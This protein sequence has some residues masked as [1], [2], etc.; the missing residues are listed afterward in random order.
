LPN[1]GLDLQ[2]ALALQLRGNFV[3]SPGPGNAFEGLPDIPI[4]EFQLKFDQGKLVTISRDLCTG[5]LP[6]FSAN[7]VGHNGAQLSDQVPATV[8]GCGG[9]GK[10]TAKVKLSKT[11]SEHPR[12]KVKADAAFSPIGEMSVR[13]PKQ[14]RL[15]RGKAL[16]KGTKASADGEAIPD[17]SLGGGSK[18]LKLDAGTGA[19]KLKVRV[20]GNAL[21]RVGEIDHKLTFKVKLTD[22]A[23]ETTTV[24]TKA[25]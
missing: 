24:K 13:L 17:S 2:G 19:D 10:P 6:M 9:S 12:M 15:S 3:L 14:L 4:S 1:L 16:D 25:R 20:A 8:E 23:G 7:F 5:P 21:N 18:K 22:L 11:G